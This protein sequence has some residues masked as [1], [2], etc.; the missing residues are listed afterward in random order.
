MKKSRHTYIHTNAG[1]VSQERSKSPQSVNKPVKNSRFGLKGNRIYRHLKDKF[2]RASLSWYN[3]YQSAGVVPQFLYLWVFSSIL[4]FVRTFVGR[5]RSVLYCA[6]ISSNIL[7]KSIWK[8]WHSLGPWRRLDWPKLHW[9]IG[10]LIWSWSV[11]DPKPSLFKRGIVGEIMSIRTNWPGDSFKAAI[12]LCTTASLNCIQPILPE[13]RVCG[14][15]TNAS[16]QW[17]HHPLNSSPF[18]K[19]LQCAH[20]ST[21]GSVCQVWVA[22]WAPAVYKK[23][24]NDGVVSTPLPIKLLSLASTSRHLD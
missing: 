4:I 19:V 24:V 23:G 14:P 15:W 8:N 10:I 21:K 3:S 11:F 2:R 12:W 7:A 17:N 5:P 13:Y 9:E 16:M 20:Q 6:K 18:R 22:D 1:L